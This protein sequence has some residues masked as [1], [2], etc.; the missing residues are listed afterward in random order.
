MS[1]TDTT[2]ARLR[3][4]MLSS[5]G[6]NAVDYRTLLSE[7]AGHLR[8][9]FA[10]RLHTAH[11]ADADDLVQEAL[12]AIHSRRMTYDP[13]KPF[14]AWL[15]A[16]AHYK[17]VD[18]V[19]RHSRRAMI[20]LDEDASVIAKDMAEAAA[21]RLDLDSLLQTVPFRTG[22]LIRRV[23]VEGA[24]IGEAAQAAGMSDSAVKV[25][26]HRGLKMLKRQFSE[27]IDD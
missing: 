27:K 16:I 18:H 19:R 9:Y 7:V 13:S 4:L 6:G 15:H 20:P 22:E 10:R 17:F 2:E 11:A 5:L 8:S 12:M 14:T 3:A 1:E 26:I 23:K 25:S 21:A 24:T